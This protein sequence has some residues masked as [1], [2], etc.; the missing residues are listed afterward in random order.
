MREAA[1]AQGQGRDLLLAQR[2]W[3][4]AIQAG[5]LAARPKA[6]VRRQPR[7]VGPAARQRHRADLS[8]D[9]AGRHPRGR[10]AVRRHR[11]ADRPAAARRGQAQGR[12]AAE[13]HR[14]AGEPHHLLL[15]GPGQRRDPRQLGQGPQPLQ[16]Q[17]RAP[18]PEPRARPRGDQAQP[19]ARLFDPRGPDGGAGHRWLDRRTGHTHQARCGACQGPAGRSRLSRRL[20]GA[21]ALPE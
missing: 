14:G 18:G 1:G 7:L 2:Q 8:A 3:H 21:D 16:G 6:A 5:V 10:A 12:P 20:R 4:R 19:D 15:H 9:Q 11:S 17:A 13:D